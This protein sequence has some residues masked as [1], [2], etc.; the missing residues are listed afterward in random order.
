ML[1]NRQIDVYE[2]RKISGI[3]GQEYVHEC[4]EMD[5]Y[6]EGKL[7]LSESV[8]LRDEWEKSLQSCKYASTPT[9]E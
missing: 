6:L 7:R 2:Y 1:W 3:K 9:H 5:A 8:K 4:K